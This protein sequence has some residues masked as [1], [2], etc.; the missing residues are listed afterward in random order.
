MNDERDVRVV[1]GVQVVGVRRATLYPSKPGRSAPLGGL[2]GGGRS[3]YGET[4]QVCFAV[5]MWCRCVADQGRFG[6]DV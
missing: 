4:C 3:P 5:Q 2:V 1:A 6:A